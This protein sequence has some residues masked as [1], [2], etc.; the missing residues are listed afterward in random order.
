MIRLTGVTR[1]FGDAE[2]GKVLRGI[3]LEVEDGALVAVLGRSGSGKTTL[4]NI[5]GGLDTG[6]AGDVEV[7]GR[8]LEGLGDKALSD[9]RNRE[10]GYVFQ[11]FHLLDHLTCAENVALPAAFARGTDTLDD[12][13]AMSRA[14]ELLERVGLADKADQHPAKLSGGEK[15]RV[16]VARALFC[17][18][19]L[20]IC[21]EPTGNLDATT[22]AEII[23]LFVRLNHDDDITFVIATHDEAIARAAS[24]VVH[25]VDGKIADGDGGNGKEATA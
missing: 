5:V 7:A 11:S 22:G 6:Y 23:D 20:I 9:Y 13:A 14:R 19:R 17:E 16:A 18:P 24:R 3:D 15:Q 4:L 10:V 12:A 8:K 1:S 25:I 2:A 21:D